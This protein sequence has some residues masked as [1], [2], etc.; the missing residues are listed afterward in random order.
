MHANL[1]QFPDFEKGL[2]GLTE[3][4]QNLPN[5]A[6]NLYLNFIHDNFQAQAFLDGINKPWPARKQSKRDNRKGARAILVL[7]GRLRRSFRVSSTTSNSFT[8]STDVPYAQMHNEGL[9]ASVTENVREHQ[10]RKST[11]SKRSGKGKQTASNA[12][13][14]TVK[15][16]SRRRTFNIPQRQFMGTSAVFN[17]R[18]SRAYEASVNQIMSNI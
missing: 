9:H 13:F 11:K 14:I 8:I 17:E 7:T 18:L 16:H 12:A 3:L 6:G 1:N 5:L 15:A 10:R 2:K 4:H